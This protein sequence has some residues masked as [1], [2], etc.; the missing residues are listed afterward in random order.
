MALGKEYLKSWELPSMDFFT[1]NH[2]T[3]QLYTIIKSSTFPITPF[4]RTLPSIATMKFSLATI[5]AAASF[6]AGGAFAAPAQEAA[7]NPLDT[8]ADCGFHAR[9]DSIWHENA[10]SRR[11]IVYRNSGGFA[12]DELGALWTA[13]DAIASMYPIQHQDPRTGE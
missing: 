11:R 6:F 4:T 3:N 2:S 7:A 5:L 13:E 10:L 9:Q 1:I 12:G 8:R